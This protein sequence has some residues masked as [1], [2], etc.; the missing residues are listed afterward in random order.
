MI[1][2]SK[3]A[4][5]S[6]RGLISSSRRP[7]IRKRPASRNL[8][9][10]LV[11]VFQ[12]TTECQG[13]DDRRRP[14]PPPPPPRAG[15]SKRQLQS[16]EEAPYP[17]ASTDAGFNPPYDESQEDLPDT[18]SSGWP[19]EDASP[20]PQDGPYGKNAQV[21]TGASTA[22]YNDELSNEHPYAEEDPYKYYN[23]GQTSS[24][25]MAR[26]VATAAVVSPEDDRPRTNVP[27]TPIHYEFPISP[28]VA[29]SHDRRRT[30]QEE[31]A[32]DEKASLQASASARRDLVTRYWATKTGKAQIMIS[33]TLIGM[34]LGNFLG[35]VWRTT[36]ATILT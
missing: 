35:K 36:M 22:W 28:E 20:Y 6:S 31:E 4:H 24:D 5:P 32:I 15:S 23:E 14:P 33:A 10:V 13:R 2:A 11:M 1:G 26:N 7:R 9:L 12:L 25:P 29:K 21:G 19:T 27:Q 8:L 34:A 3:A 16:R 18:K 30:G 17:Y